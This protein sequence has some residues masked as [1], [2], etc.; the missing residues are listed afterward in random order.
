MGLK[1]HELKA[2]SR[3]DL[4]EELA[5]LEKKLFELRGQTASSSSRQKLSEIKDVRKDV[6]RV[7]T[8]LMNQQR[9]ALKAKY[10]GQKHIPKDI[11][12]NMTKAERSELP[13]KW[14][15]KL[16]AK[17]AKRAKYL[18]PVKFALKA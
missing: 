14:A 5:G 12:P 15:N 18:K 10:A 7:K 17:C 6:A 16:T 9:E 13:A 8:V 11:R 1:A 2:K 4:L 3:A